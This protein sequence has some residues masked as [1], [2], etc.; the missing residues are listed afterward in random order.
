MDSGIKYIIS[1]FTSC[2][3][4][5][6]IRTFYL[7]SNAIKNASLNKQRVN[8]FLTLAVIVQTKGILVQEDGNNRQSVYINGFLTLAIIVQTKGILMEEDGHCR[9]FRQSVNIYSR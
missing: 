2:S 7:L 8:G 5:S 4:T 3:S 6:V 1:R 9:R